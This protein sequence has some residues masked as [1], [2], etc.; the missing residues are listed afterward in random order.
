LVAILDLAINE[1]FQGLRQAEVFG[2]GI[3][4]HL[5]QMVAYGCQVQLLQFLL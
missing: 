1:S 2:R 4:Q 5:I 3:S